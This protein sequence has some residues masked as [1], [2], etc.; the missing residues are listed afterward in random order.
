MSFEFT[1]DD[2]RM[3]QR[4]MLDKLAAHVDKIGSKAK[5]KDF[6]GIELLDTESKL[7]IKDVAEAFNNLVKALQE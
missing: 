1:H 5:A 3:G 2:M 7:T 4:A 6:S